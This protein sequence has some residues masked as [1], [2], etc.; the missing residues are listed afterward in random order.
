MKQSLS[1]SNNNFDFLRLLGALLVIISHSYALTLAGKD[2][3]FQ[4]TGSEPFSFLGVAMFFV[5]SGFLITQS[6]HYDPTR[7]FIWKRFLKIIPGLIGVSLFTVFI[8]GPV[9]TT[10]PIKEYFLI[11]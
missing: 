4:L 3:L 5:I 9:V 11:Q 8:L 1:H 6:G 7:H 10:V 2:P